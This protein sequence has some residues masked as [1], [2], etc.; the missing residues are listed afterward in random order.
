MLDSS[1]GY[2]AFSSW[3]T[4]QRTHTIRPDVVLAWARD[5]PSRT[6]VLDEGENYYFLTQ[7]A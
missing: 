4:G 2:E 7:K 6:A 5:L 3:W 1:N